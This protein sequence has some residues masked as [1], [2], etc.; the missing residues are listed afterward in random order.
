MPCGNR[1][2]RKHKDTAQTLLK[3]TATKTAT[4]M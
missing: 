2:R 4:S 1:R 3:I